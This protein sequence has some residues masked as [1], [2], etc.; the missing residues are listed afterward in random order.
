MLSLWHVHHQSRGFH[1]NR[2]TSVFTKSYIHY[3]QTN[4]QK[5]KTTTMAFSPQVN[6]NAKAGQLLQEEGVVWLVQ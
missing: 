6:Y 2:V 1:P 3:I 4:K 5:K